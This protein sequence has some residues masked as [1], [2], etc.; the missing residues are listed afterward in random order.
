MDIK[1]KNNELVIKNGDIV[2]DA[3]DISLNIVDT[4]IANTGEWKFNPLSAG[5]LGQIINSN[6]ATVVVN[7]AKNKVIEDG[8]TEDNINN[9][10]QINLLK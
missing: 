4:M 6:N 3:N 9:Y 1:L 7:N 5:N 2:I 10:L 8:F